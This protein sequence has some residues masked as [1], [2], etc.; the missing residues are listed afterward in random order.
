MVTLLMSIAMTAMASLD[1][2][3]DPWR[4]VNDGVMGGR[5]S[6]GMVQ[7]EDALKFTGELS[8]ENNGG[9]SSVRR[10]VEESGLDPQM[11]NA[12]FMA[13]TAFFFLYLWLMSKRLAVES[14]REEVDHLYK[15]LEL[16]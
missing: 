14:S 7:A 4:S 2:R 3:A 9:F 1:M 11:L 10:L 13:L 15:E 8:L 12:L 6:G 5:S 16:A